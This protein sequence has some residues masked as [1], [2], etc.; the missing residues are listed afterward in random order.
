MSTTKR[1]KCGG[2]LSIISGDEY[3]NCKDCHQ[4]YDLLCANVDK[5][6]YQ[7]M[8]TD[9]KR[10]WL[11]DG[12]RNKMP[13][14]NKNDTPVR[15]GIAHRENLSQRPLLEDAHLN[16]TLRNK[17]NPQK[18]DINLA[19]LTS[20][21]VRSAL[22]EELKLILPTL[23]ATELAPVRQQLQDLQE[24]VQFMSNQYEDLSKCYEKLQ[25]EHTAIKQECMNLRISTASLT[26]RI[27]TM[28]QYA[29]DSN[30]EIQGVPESKSEMVIDI[31]KKIAA[32]VSYTIPDSGILSCTR[33]A[34]INR[35]VKRPRAIIVKTYSTRCRDEF[36]SAVARYNKSHI[37]KKLCSSLLGISGENRQIFLSEHL[38]PVNKSLHAATR[39][40]AKEHDYKY[41]WVRNGRIFMRK[42]ETSRFI[43]VKNQDTLNSFRW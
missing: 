33:V 1:L 3:L 20:V 25:N 28:E 36:L 40:K 35:D 23:L 8:K 2:C 15:Q 18:T 43:H 10:L 13:K 21:E 14:G 7:Q 6:E 22:R 34:S 19:S 5:L 16:V 11:C 12:C 29:R 30:L 37:N 27:N 24:S 9:R 26:E 39:I 32:V 17:P 31:V 4:V 41:V 38:S 42:D